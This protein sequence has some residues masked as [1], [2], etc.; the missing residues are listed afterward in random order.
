MS[1]S[2]TK[3]PKTQGT[4]AARRASTASVGAALAP[5]AYG[6]D[7]VDRP[8][9]RENRTGLPDR[10]KAGIEGLSGLAMDD[11]R[12]HYDSPKPAGLLA[13]A[14]TRGT[15][16]HI[17][18]GQQA[19]LP[20]E[21]WHVVQQKQ[22]RVPSTTRIKDAA[23]NDS[24]ELEMQADAFGRRALQMSGAM[25]NVKRDRSGCEAVSRDQGFPP[26]NQVVSAPTAVI[27]CAKTRP[28]NANY[29]KRAAA[30]LRLAKQPALGGAA[31]KSKLQ[32]N[33]EV[34]DGDDD[35]T[36]N[37]IV[38]K[39]KKGGQ[40]HPIWMINVPAKNYFDELAALK[41]QIGRIRWFERRD[42]V[43]QVPRRSMRTVLK[44]DKKYRMVG[45]NTGRSR[46]NYFSAPTLRY[47]KNSDGTALYVKGHL[48]NDHLGGTGIAPNLVPLTAEKHSVG[49][50]TG[51]NDANACHNRQVEEPVKNWVN[52]HPRTDAELH[53]R[54]DS[55]EPSSSPR[56]MTARVNDFTTNF[57]AAA[58][59]STNTV[60]TG[61]QLCS[62]VAVGLPLWPASPDPGNESD[63]CAAVHG[64]NM[65]VSRL[66]G[67]LRENA[68]LWKTEDKTIPKGIQCTAYYTEP[69]DI[70]TRL[71]LTTRDGFAIDKYVISNILPTKFGAPFKK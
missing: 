22:G 25:G 47:R 61:K 30:E 21:A 2:S 60:M 8:G 27:Q 42:P 45:S 52:S 46:V 9:A 19:Y 4:P 51:S 17:G 62:T 7:F 48:L 29:V 18:P 56:A 26:G 12:V 67:L 65:S 24:R 38:H 49:S 32:K 15:E 35:A 33:A 64:G 68:D 37:Y 58:K 69:P 40:D 44:R 23:F 63:L 55:L 28:H 16:I 71:S 31:K 11:V 1:Q 6:I 14:Y 50:K 57:E 20:H 13:L 39:K 41:S 5:P 10:L 34:L 66:A 54:V 36:L 3:A 59:L 53:Y 70:N 43:T